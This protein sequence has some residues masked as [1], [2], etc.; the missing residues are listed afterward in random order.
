MI[1]SLYL[2]FTIVFTVFSSCGSDETDWPIDETPDNSRDLELAQSLSGKWH[3]CS[4]DVYLGIVGDCGIETMDRIL[5]FNVSKNYSETYVEY[6]SYGEPHAVSKSVRGNWNIK[7]GKIMLNDWDGNLLAPI[8]ISYISENDLTMT[9]TKGNTA[10][11]KRVGHDF[12]DL[13]TRILGYWYEYT[14][15]RESP[16]YEFKSDGL[17]RHRDYYWNNSTGGDRPIPGESQL[18]WNLEGTSLTLTSYPVQYKKESYTIS[19]CNAYY[20][21][22]GDNCLRRTKWK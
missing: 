8:S 3:F 15:G 21:I 1:R 17:V 9:D 13:S 14:T 18:L 12:D 5:E 22:Y 2:L 16:F 11:Y 7:D 10:T 4:G 6:S 19:C 20:L